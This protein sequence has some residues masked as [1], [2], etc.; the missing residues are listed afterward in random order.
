MFFL[1][2]LNNHFHENCFSLNY[3]YMLH[4]SIMDCISLGSKILNEKNKN[5]QSTDKIIKARAHFR[6][7]LKWSIGR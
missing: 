4:V 3:D 6:K 7:A 1:R 5:L 2:L